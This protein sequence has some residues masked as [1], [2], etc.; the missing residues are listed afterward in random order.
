MGKEK[1]RGYRDLK[2][3]QLAYQLASDVHELTKGF[4][5]EEKYSL[6]DQ[7]RR[8]SR[9]IPGNIAEAWKKRRYPKSFISKLIDCAGEAGET[10]VWLDFS[11]DFGYMKADDHERFMKKYD[12]VNRM[13]YGM[14]D[15]PEKFC[16]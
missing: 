4:P 8:S 10:E 7:M 15:K 1:H 13:L 3:Y 9:S 16:K 12:E 6:T 2:V 14:I 11:R 5:K